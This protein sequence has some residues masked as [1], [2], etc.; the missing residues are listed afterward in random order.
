MPIASQIERHHAAVAL[1][2]PIASEL[3][4]GSGL[5]SCPAPG[6]PIAMASLP[7]LD[8]VQ[9]LFFAST[10]GAR[11]APFLLQKNPPSQAAAAL[12]PSAGGVWLLSQL[13]LLSLCDTFGMFD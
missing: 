13:N 5:L 9:T 2:G 7:V 1:G 4:N 12:S 10:G 8:G 11:F 6:P 3:G